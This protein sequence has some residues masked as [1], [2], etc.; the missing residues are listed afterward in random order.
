MLLLL[1]GAVGALTMGPGPDLLR[2]RLP[3]LLPVLLVLIALPPA[4]LLPLHPITLVLLLLCPGGPAVAAAARS[5]HCSTCLNSKSNPWCPTITGVCPGSVLLCTKVI[6]CSNAA[7]TWTPSDS[8]SSLDSPAAHEA[9]GVR[10]WCHHWQC[11]EQAAMM[12][13]LP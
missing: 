5:K 11:A 13:L 12:L 3:L 8:T 9:V 10:T 1:S 6:S 2:Y 4:L 7:S